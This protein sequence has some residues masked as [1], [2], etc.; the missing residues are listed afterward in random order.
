MGAKVVEYNHYGFLQNVILNASNATSSPEPS[1]FSKWR[2]I[3]SRS[4]AILK[5]KKTLGTRLQAPNSSEGPTEPVRPRLF[6]R[7]PV[8]RFPGPAFLERHIFQRRPLDKNFFV[9]TGAT[10][11]FCAGLES[12]ILNHYLSVL[13]A[14]IVYIKI[15]ILYIIIPSL[16]C[17]SLIS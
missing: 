7:L 16:I 9:P 13:F 8:T 17:N 6:P 5:T 1:R 12:R 2:R 11:Y 4:A 15:I 3:F 10:C 14:V